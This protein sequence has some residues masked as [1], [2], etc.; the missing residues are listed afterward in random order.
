[1][2]IELCL[3]VHSCPVSFR[4][5]LQQCDRVRTNVYICTYERTPTDAYACPHTRTNAIAARSPAATQPLEKEA[6]EGE[7]E[8]EEEEPGMAVRQSAHRGGSGGGSIRGVCGGGGGDGGRCDDCVIVGGGGGGGGMLAPPAERES[9]VFALM[10]HNLVVF[11]ATATSWPRAT[12]M[13][14]QMR[15]LR[16]AQATAGRGRRRHQ[17]G[18]GGAGLD[19]Q[20]KMHKAAAS[21]WALEQPSRIFA[22]HP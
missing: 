6:Q 4:W 17:G 18:G 7:Q 22:A 9:K 1:M 14:F 12:Q 16:G 20:A 21:S 8:A 2:L 11:V 15:R 19:W 3:H 10:T 5:P 13:R